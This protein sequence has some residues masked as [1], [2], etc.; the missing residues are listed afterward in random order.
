MGGPISWSTV[1]GVVEGDKQLPEVYCDI[2][3]GKRS[4]FL[5]SECVGELVKP[6]LELSPL[7]RFAR[8]RGFNGVW[9]CVDNGSDGWLRTLL[10]I[11][12]RVFESDFPFD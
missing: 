1:L 6:S 10:I 2:R 9:L 7:I 11:D 5:Y 8:E 3:T 4:A 12:D